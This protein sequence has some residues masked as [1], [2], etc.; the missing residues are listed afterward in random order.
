MEKRSA[1]HPQVRVWLERSTL[2]PYVS[3]FCSR[4]QR[5]R[6]CEST[7]HCYLYCVAH[8]AHWAHRH[9]LALDQIDERATTRFVA[10][11]LPDCDCPYP[12]KR[13]RADARAALSHLLRTLSACGVIRQ[14][15]PDS[16][17]L[18]AE[19]ASFDH[20]MA[21]VQGLARSTRRQRVHIVRRFLSERFASRPFAPGR[22]RPADIRRFVL[23]HGGAHSTG[24][25]HV[26][27]GAVR[28][29]L[30]FRAVAGDFVQPLIDAV[31]SVAHWRLASLPEVLSQQE[32]QRLLD[33]FKQL[34]GSPKRAYA[35]T[36]CL[37]DLGLRAS[38]VVGLKLSDVDWRSGT[39]RLTANKSR[40]VDIL[41]LP[42]ATGQAIAD[43]LQAERPETSSRALFARH[44]APFERPVQAGVVRS[45][46]R[47]AYVRSG[48]PHSRVH[49]LRHSLA[50]R[51]LK[52]GTPLKEIAD[53]L[54]HRSL[55][56][57]VIYTKVDT[58][59]LAAVAMPWP[60]RSL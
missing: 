35:M 31:P 28:C 52:E 44:C 51:L 24:T 13:G 21:E 43:Y 16:D 11:H 29:Y 38:E 20:Y 55:D 23:H 37:T 48:L 46:V 50:S 2:Q 8:F 14:S 18:Q 30:R 22:M 27:G 12:V 4:L 47:Q 34:E 53:I 19:L 36:R 17:P 45:V 5:S 39:I 58:N 33:S 49:L 15:R 54:R 32:I 60:G 42:A 6:Y 40:R 9:R 10:E 7:I 59:R 57:S 3:E 56:T 41:P 25:I 26:M 1:V